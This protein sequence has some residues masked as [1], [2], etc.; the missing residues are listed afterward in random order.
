MDPAPPPVSPHSVE[1]DTGGD[2]LPNPLP[3]P[4]AEA[5]AKAAADAAAGGAKKGVCACCAKA[6]C[7]GVQS[8]AKCTSECA[9]CGLRV[10]PGNRNLVCV[11][12]TDVDVPPRDTMKMGNDASMPIKPY[13]VLKSANAKHRKKETSAAEA[14]AAGATEASAP[15]AT[16]ADGAHAN[17]HNATSTPPEASAQEARRATLDYLTWFHTAPH[18]MG[19][20]RGLGYSA[21]PDFLDYAVLFLE[22]C[23]TS[24]TLGNASPK[25]A[26]AAF[27]D[28][29]LLA[30]GGPGMTTPSEHA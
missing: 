21:L 14:N 7:P 1:G 16:H 17:E 4:W 18:N 3:D 20:A 2:E 8:W 13:G 25:L 28:L 11:V 26:G 9:K 12:C 24:D 10:C 6:G 5:K 29:S 22:T 23:A 15:P 19:V 27:D 30:G